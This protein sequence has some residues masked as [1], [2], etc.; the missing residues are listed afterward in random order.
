MVMSEK[1]LEK[2]AGD[3]VDRFF[4]EKVALN[5]GVT[6]MAQSQNLNEEQVRRLVE[7]VN[8]SA[9]LRK[10]NDMAQPD[11]SQADRVVE[12]ETADPN[13]VINRMLGSAKDEM[14]SNVETPSEVDTDTDL[15]TDLPVTRSDEAPAEPCECAEPKLSEARVQKHVVVNSLHKTAGLFKE[16][17]WQARNDFTNATQDLL[18]RFRRLHGASFEEF[19]KDAFYQLGPPA[20]PYLQMIRQSLGKPTADYDYGDMK[21]YARVVDMNTP[22]MRL[23]RNMMKASQ[24]AIDSAKGQEKVGEHIARIA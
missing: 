5:D 17:A 20:A 21:K 11:G 24:T 23:F 13:A 22:E 16:Q 18:T 12:F 8:T 15:S 7:A 2:F 6:D 3:I 19:E 1:L 9:F 10:F 14:D 4:G